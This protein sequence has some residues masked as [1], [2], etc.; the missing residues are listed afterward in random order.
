MFFCFKW[1]GRNDDAHA[2][3]HDDPV[4]DVTHASMCTHIQ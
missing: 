4:C 2:H 1:G 3:P